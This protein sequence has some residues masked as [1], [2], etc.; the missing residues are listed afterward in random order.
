MEYPTVWIQGLL[1]AG[2]NNARIAGM[3]RNLSSYYYKDD[4]L[5]FCLVPANCSRLVVPKQSL[6]SRP[7]QHQFFLLPV[8]GAE[9]ITKRSLP[10]S[11]ISEGFIIL[12]ENPEYVRED[13]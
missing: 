7:T 5:L 8:M 2:T 9:L 11:P 12:K 4:G 13:N 10:L 3:L 6:V 1:G